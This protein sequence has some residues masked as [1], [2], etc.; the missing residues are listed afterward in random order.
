MAQIFTEVDW[1]F[2]AD[3]AL[4]HAAYC[5]GNSN[6]ASELRLRTEKFGATAR[7]RERMRLQIV[8]P[9]EDT[10][11]PRGGLAGERRRRL[12]LLA[13]LD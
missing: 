12:E 2:L 1:A 11:P 8:E 7:D 9:N 4:L 6:L 3:T 13:G 10:P 5:H